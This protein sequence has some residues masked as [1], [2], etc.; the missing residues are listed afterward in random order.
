MVEPDREISFEGCFNFRDLGGYDAS[1]GRRTKWRRLFRSDSLS[2]LTEQ[3]SDRME[4]EL[5]VRT[6]LDLRSSAMNQELPPKVRARC[7]S[8]PLL[9]DE[10][11]ALAA[12]R[13]DLSPR[14]F[15]RATGDSVEDAMVAKVFSFLATESSYPLAFHCLVGKD[16]TGLVAALILGVLGVDDEDIVRDYAMTERNMVRTIARLRSVGRLPADGSFTKEIPSTFFETPPEAM[17]ALLK[18]IRERFGSIRAYVASCGVDDAALGGVE[19]QLL[20]DIQRR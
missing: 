2:R 1:A 10:A 9:S 17:V 18:E 19:R 8:V 7:V 13:M 5:G 11:E 6:V 20:T 14:T 15:M 16:R 12:S 3:D 4:H